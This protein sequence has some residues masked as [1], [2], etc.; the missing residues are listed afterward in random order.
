MKNRRNFFWILLAGSLCFVAGSL[1]GGLPSS[2]ASRAKVI[3]AQEFQLLDTYGK[4]R[5]IM[6]INAKGNLVV[7]MIDTK[8]KVCD[9]LEVSPEMVAT[10]KQSAAT[11]QRVDQAMKK[12]G[13][14]W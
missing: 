5:A 1:W 10:A 12:L 13:N 4:P 11:L 9:Q 7:F 2:W 8:G 6:E 14:I 3:K